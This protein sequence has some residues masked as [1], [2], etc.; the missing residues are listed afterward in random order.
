MFV[1]LQMGELFK[2]FRVQTRGCVGSELLHIAH[3]VHYTASFTVWNTGGHIEIRSTQNM[4]TRAVLLISYREG[5]KII[6]PN[7]DKMYLLQ[8]KPT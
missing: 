6:L 5:Y 2:L 7:Y 4:S 1:V 3:C 8:K